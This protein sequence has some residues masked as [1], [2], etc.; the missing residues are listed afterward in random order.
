MA[1]SSQSSGIFLVIFALLLALLPVGTFGI[2]YFRY[3][4]GKFR[5]K[6]GWGSGS[7]GAGRV[8]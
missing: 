3:L 4:D 6:L 8:L 1:I 5:V 2:V 7:D